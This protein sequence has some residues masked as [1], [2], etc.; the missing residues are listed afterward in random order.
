MTPRMLR[1]FRKFDANCNLQ[2]YSSASLVEGLT[3]GSNFVRQI[4]WRKEYRHRLCVRSCKGYVYSEVHSF[5]VAESRDLN[6]LET[7]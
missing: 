1:T 5:C 4:L 2:R 7:S 6:E 3:K